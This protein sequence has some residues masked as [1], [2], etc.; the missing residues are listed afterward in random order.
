MRSK[1]KYIVDGIKFDSKTEGV[2]Y[3]ILRDHKDIKIIDR[4]K[5]FL[6]IDR[7]VFKS[8]PT[9][10]LGI[11]RKMVYTP[12]FIIS[13]KGRDKLIAMETKGHARKDYMM[14]KKLFIHFHG[15]EYDFY[16]CKDKSDGAQLKKDL[17]VLTKTNKE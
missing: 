7:F 2:H 16:E 8:L 14:R 5:M 9:Y 11:I 6:L 13:V 4:Q 12:D 3:Q 10:R 15:D 17:E 1:K